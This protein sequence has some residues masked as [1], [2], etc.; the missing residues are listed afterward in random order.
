MA[1][2]WKRLLFQILLLLVCCRHID[3][4]TPGATPPPLVPITSLATDERSVSLKGESHT[5]KVELLNPVNLALQCTWTGNQNKAPNI[6]GF[7]RKDGDEVENSRVTVQLE[8]DQYELKR[9]FSIVNEESLGSYSCVFGSEAKIEFV[10]AAPQVGEVRDKPIVSYV[11]DS[12]VITCKME[13]P[14]PKPSTWNWYK[15]NGTDKISAVA[16]P[17]R[18]EI[19]NEESKTKLVVH[20]L[21]E[22]DGGLY[23]CGAVYAISTTMGRVELKVISFQE[24]LKPFIAIVIEVV[25]LVAAILLYERSQSKKD[26]TP[27]NGTTD[28][29]NT[30]AHRDNTGPEETSTRQR[31]I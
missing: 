28:Q 26:Y 20:N 9:V 8:G 3:T 11:G 5:E 1:D 18:Y 14:K 19:E 23:Y 4:K 10:L 29:M 24:P 15:A 21:T 27:E 22:A 7:W 2:S 31:K 25:V 17:L 12:V 16:E 6:T 30:M 13:E